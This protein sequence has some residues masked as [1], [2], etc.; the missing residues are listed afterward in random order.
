M[1]DRRVKKIRNQAID[2]AMSGLDI[3]FI[4]EHP[5]DPIDQGATYL[6][7]AMAGGEDICLCLRRL[8]NELK[9]KLTKKGI[10]LDFNV[11]TT[12]EN[13]DE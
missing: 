7:G 3:L 13:E 4:A 2:L 12:E 5:E 9:A 10:R 6:F 1:A 11:S 8:L